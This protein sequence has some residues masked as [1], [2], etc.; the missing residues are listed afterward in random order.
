MKLKN[1]NPFELHVE[2][3]A[4]AIVGLFLLYVVWA[5]I[6][7]DRF[8]GADSIEKDVLSIAKRVEDKLDDPAPEVLT[9]FQVPEYAE[10]FIADVNQPLTPAS[11]VDG[12]G[13]SQLA[14]A[15]VSSFGIDLEGDIGPTEGQ[16]E[17]RPLKVPAPVEVAARSELVTLDPTEEPEIIQAIGGRPPYDK[18]VASIAARFDVASMLEQIQPQAG[19]M[20]VTPLPIPD[21]WM[22]EAFVVLDV[23]V[24]RREQLADGT[25]SQPTLLPPMPGRLTFRGQLGQ[26]TRQN[27][28]QYID[29]VR[30]QQSKVVQPQGYLLKNAV[31]NPPSLSEPENQ[32]SDGEAEP[33]DVNNQTAEQIRRLEARIRQLQT[34]V[35][36]LTRQRQQMQQAGRDTSRIDTQIAS[37]STD[38]RTLEAQIRQLQQGRTAEPDMLPDPRFQ[39]EPGIRRPVPGRNGMVAPGVE[40]FTGSL[41]SQ[42][43]LDVWSQDLTA[44]PGK[45]YQYRVRIVTTNPLFGRALPES[46]QQLRDQFALLGEWSAWSDSVETHQMR[47]FWVVG[48][49]EGRG[50]L[51]LE[52]WRFHDGIW[53]SAEVNVSPGDPIGLPN[54]PWKLLAGEIAPA[55]GNLGNVP[56]LPAVDPTAG[57]IDFSTGLYVVDVRFDHMKLRRFGGVADRTYQ[58]VYTENGKKLMT[59]F[60][61]NRDAVEKA[62]TR[63]L[64]EGAFM[65]AAERLQKQREAYAE[66]QRRRAEQNGEPGLR[67][68]DRFGPDD[69]MPPD[70]VLPPGLR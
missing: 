29:A 30:Q 23:Q 56:P 25:W 63:L 15:V 2:K 68:D 60:R 54:T 47:Y 21:A 48:G 67:P 57:P 37:S 45:T 50:S 17:Y 12:V 7:S 16:P 46:Q 34:Q 39:D 70:M 4:L 28:M 33:G 5:Y 6:L 13:S 43:T 53:K 69:R 41:L 20:N 49:A 36:R 64:G 1:I 31:W 32:T 26:V 52:L 8:P 27:A 58:L 22:R 10:E 14:V 38:I 11:P 51:E 40:S 44:E 9:K 3:I 66:R 35:T 62:K 61:A 18:A 42:A 24:E 19:D 65:T 59:K 55:I